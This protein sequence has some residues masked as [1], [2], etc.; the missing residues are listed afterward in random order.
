MSIP[1]VSIIMTV[2]NAERYLRET[3]DSI[4]RQTLKD[5]EI[6][7]VD[8]NSADSTLEI[9]H[10]YQERGMEIQVQQ[11]RRKGIGAAKNE[12]LVSAIGEFI[13]F[14]DADDY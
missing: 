10:E 13:T 5:I 1:K 4:S 11:Q 14:L 2:C 7:C 9:I 8:F 3:L 12:G 6:V